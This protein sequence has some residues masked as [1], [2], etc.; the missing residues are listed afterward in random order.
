MKQLP[1]RWKIMILSYTVVIFS[2][3]VGGI[4][5]ISNIQESEEKDLRIRTMNTARTVAELSD[6]RKAV[7]EPTGW[8]TVNPL[9]EEIR[10]INGT[11]YIVVMNMEQIRYSHPVKKMIGEVSKGKDE[12]AAFAEHIYFSKAE[13][14]MGTFIRAFV[15]IKDA[16]LNQIGVVVVGNKIPIFIE[17]MMNLTT[18]IL[19]IVVLTLIFGLIGSFMLANHIK[20]QMFQLEPYEIKRMHEES[21]ATFHAMNEGVIAIDNKE[22]VT[23]FNEKAKKTFNVHGNFIGQ[24]IRAILK[25]TRLPEIVERNQ[26]VYNEEIQVSGKVIVSTRIPI[27]KGHELIGAVA[28]FQDRT[29]VTQLAEELTGVKNFV[30]ALRVQNHEHMNKLHT[31][32]GLIQLG[33]PEK[34]L[35]LAFNMTEEQEFVTNFLSEKVKNDAIAGLL[36]SKIRRGKELGISVVIDQNSYLAAFPNR[37]DQH[38]FVVLFGNLIENAF[39]A[40]EQVDIENKRIDISIE[41]TA[42]V[43]AILVEDNGAGIDEAHLPRLYEK[44]FTRNKSEGTG[45]GLF[46]VKQII[47]KGRGQIDV[48][49]LQGEGTTMIITF[50]MEVEEKVDGK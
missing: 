34:A 14:E 12:K 13:G 44:G 35:Q 29:E 2:L 37:L 43:C 32:A 23:I 47:E 25:D 20:K 45:Y 41:Q 9:V 39:G 19:F 21:T 6:I 17:V 1:I 5:I 27:R 31:L 8:E 16:D 36:L 10:M 18:D 38:D 50:P 15:P 22:I 4:I 30:E 42:A 28:I 46:L 26:A 48:S 33:K 40:F 24:P 3:L 7:Q 49:S 11:D